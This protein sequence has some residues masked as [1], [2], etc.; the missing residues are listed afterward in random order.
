MNISA[1]E[2]DTGL[3]KDTLRMWERRYG[4]P[5]PHR[6]ENGERLYPI[7][8]VEKLRLVKRLMDRGHRPG[9]I[10]THSLEDLIALGS[11]PDGTSRSRDE[12]E[13]FLHLVKTHQLADLRRHLAQTQMKQGLQRFILDT[14]APLTTAV[15]EAWMHGEVAVFEE[16]LYTEQVLSVLRN[17]IG[18]VQPQGHSPRVLLTSLPDEPH[19]MG[20]LMV[21]ALLAIEGAACISLGTETPLADIVLA[22]DACRADVVALSFSAAYG[23]KNAAAGLA[24]L[25]AMLPATVE[26]WA[27]G[28]S[29]ARLRRHIPGTQLMRSLAALLDQLK[30]WRDSHQPASAAYQ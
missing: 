2:R 19:S 28:A 6:D 11:L 14:L 26:L 15:G 23:E 9:K 1:V 4:Y 18:S 10:I 27:G 3:S 22:A 30:Q 17:A 7:S 13:T 16:H 24:E 29:I 20:L 8:Q 21:E 25:R 12:L 5:D